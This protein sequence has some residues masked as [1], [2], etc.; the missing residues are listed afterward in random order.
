MHLPDQIGAFQQQLGRPEWV[1]QVGAAPFQLGRQGAVEDDDALL[2][3]EWPEGVHGSHFV[4]DGYGA[5]NHPA[6]FIH[7]SHLPSVKK[8]RLKI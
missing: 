2:C 7:T 3:Q 8:T 6:Y 4:S 5:R 1:V